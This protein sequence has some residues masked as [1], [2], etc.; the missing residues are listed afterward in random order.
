MKRLQSPKRPGTGDTKKKKKTTV[1]FMDED[2]IDV[3]NS[4]VSRHINKKECVGFVPKVPGA[5]DGEICGCGHRK[6]QHFPDAFSSPVPPETTWDPHK[7]VCEFPT[8]AH[9][10]MTFT[11]TT[12]TWAKYVRASNNTPPWQLF[13]LMTQQWGLGV[14][15]LLISVTG[16]AKNFNISP[17][18][19]TQFSRGLV[20]AAQSTGA[21]I[22]TGGS[23]A[24]VMKHVGEAVRDF[25]RKDSEIVLIGIATWGIVYNRAAL[26]SKENGVP[27]QYTVDEGSQGALCCLDHNHT[28]F[29]LVDDGTYGRYGVE[30]PLRTKLE[31]FISEQ[32][33]QKGGSAIKI[34]I[35]CVVLEGGP[36]TLDTIYSSMCH[37]TPCVIVEG[38]GRVA[39]I[40]AQVANL[41]PSRISISLVKEKLQSLFQDTYESFT[42][43]QIVMWTKKIQDIV[44]MGS[45]LTILREE[46]TLEQGMD[47]AILQA[48]LKASRS[49]DHYG[50]E[51]WDHQLKLAVSW[52]R[53]DIAQ[54]QIFTEDWAWKTADLFP[55]LEVSLIEDKPSFVRLFLELG[56]SLSEFLTWDTLTRL[57]NHLDESCSFHSK[58]DKQTTLETSTGEVQIQAIELHHVSRVLQELLGELTEALY[59][60]TKSRLSRTLHQINIKISSKVSSLK[61]VPIA[62]KHLEHPARDLLIWCI[63]Q[64][65]AELAEIIW[66]QNQ[67]CIV[68]ALTCSKILKQLSKEEEDT[69]NM[70]EMTALADVYE[71]RAVGVFS[72]CYRND[73]MRAEFLLIRVSPIW[74]RT[75]SL[76]L[77]QESQGRIFM[78]Q[79]GVQ[80]FLTK[81]WWGYLSVDNGFLQVLLCMLLFPLIYSGLITFSISTTTPNISVSVHYQ[82]TQCQ[83]K[84]LQGIMSL[85]L[86]SSPPPYSCLWKFLIFFTAPVVK[87]YGNVVSYCGFLWLFAYVLMIDFQTSPS[88]A[89]YLLYVWVFSILCEELRQ[90][91]FDPDRLG[92][93]IKSTQY[94]SEF[95]NQVDSLALIL[96]VVGLI[97]R[98]VSTNTVYLGRVFLSLD[99][100]IFCMRL[101][102]NFTVSKVLGPKIIML[103]RMVKDIFFFLFLL[104]IWI[105]AYGV[106][107]QA[108][109]TTNETRLNWIFRNVVYE[110][111][112]TLFGQL[113][114]NVDSLSFDAK[115]C[116]ENGT[117]PTMPRC[118]YN[119]GSGN[120]LFPEWLTIILMCLYLLLAN[121]LLLNLLIA[122]F[123]YTFG[124]IESHTD[125]I[126]KFYRFG[127]IKEYNERP[128]APP[129]FILISHLYF[130]LKHVIYKRPTRHHKVLRR[131]LD[132]GF[133]SSLLSWESYMK[134]NYQQNEEQRNLHA[135]ENLVRDTAESVSSVLRLL[136]LEK[137]RE[138]NHLEARMAVV[139]D[140]LVQSSRYLSWIFSALKEKGFTS[141]T[142]ILAHSSSVD[143]ET[144]GGFISE[145]ICVYHV[146]A[147][148]LNYPESN[149]IRYPVPDEMVPWEVEFPTYDPPLYIANRMD[150]GTYNPA[151][152]ATKKDRK[153]NELDGQLDLRSSCGTYTVRDGLPL[154]PMGRTGLRGVGNLRW[155]GPN[156][157]LH[158]VVTRWGKRFAG[159]TDKKI[160]QKRLEVLVV[161]RI[162]N[163]LWALPG[164]TLD[165]GEE[166]PVK[167]QS[168]VK[169][170]FLKGFK[171][172]LKEGTEV[173]RGYLDDNRNTDNSWIETV[174]INVHLENKDKLDKL[175]QNLDESNVTLSLRW[176][177]LD[178]KIPLYANEKDILQKT[179]EYLGAHY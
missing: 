162:E 31:K 142:Q 36:G 158:P 44:R 92:F 172:L 46:T 173:F 90:L 131:A 84:Y 59:P 67:D 2:K 56:V 5:S 166:I 85:P 91:L 147:R 63:V 101:M 83:Y 14:P 3:L 74:G 6:D 157:S 175:L 53:P 176:Q 148:K 41:S 76:Q 94:I 38:S 42:E 80:M 161:K 35:V 58:L 23:H 81:T 30:I 106:A 174:A 151:A 155:F 102:H 167:L 72:E 138:G 96:F 7:H 24:G 17:R 125:Q 149:I 124:E 153:Y 111:Y 159:S 100:M 137:G 37:N 78:G 135:Q 86:F 29:V 89:E 164:G 79:A 95:W 144:N 169:K 18:L 156:H 77:A 21:W 71:E 10:G 8:D 177:L 141:N 66:S 87:F 140:Q 39:D 20:T 116:S 73:E 98:L 11:G 26:L 54:T 165:P 168:I 105:I 49:T 16:G 121:I 19:K 123:S 143:S 136:K 126:W 65:R 108:I 119:D 34:P 132:E 122:M 62:H 130:L 52:N 115:K 97:C 112:L 32:T 70:E 160:S 99:F 68:G 170:Q 33:M 120:T 22:I 48:L 1:Q 25:S 117:D 145:N 133:E 107:K 13:D 51:N 154:N 113:P 134:D 110:P 12:R 60:E 64:N 9:G 88:W 28:H 43:K 109:L 93:S 47:V 104:A 82:A 40:I 163:E 178:R 4:W 50:Q 127:L 171:A 128:A 27:A 15:N 61:E 114:S 129:P 139:E 75:T 179:A 152:E 118:V 69:E 45:L 103:R 146:N 55:A 150:R 57:Y